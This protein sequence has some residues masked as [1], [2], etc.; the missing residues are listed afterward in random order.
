MPV[1]GHI[2]PRNIVRDSGKNFFSIHRIAILFPHIAARN[3]EKEFFFF[4]YM[5]SV[6]GLR[7]HM[8]R[9]GENTFSL[10]VLRLN[11]LYADGQFFKKYC[12]VLVITPS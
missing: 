4:V 9:A 7:R 3:F 5:A 2:F 6:S 12:S 8:S 10:D 11:N 1:Q